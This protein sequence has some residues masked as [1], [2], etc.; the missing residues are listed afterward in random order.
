M[1]APPP[2]PPPP[3]PPLP[4]PTAY[5][6]F[7]NNPAPL[8]SVAVGVFAVAC[9][10]LDHT[11]FGTTNGAFEG[12]VIAGIVAVI[13]GVAGLLMAI[14]YGIASAVFSIIG[15]GLGLVAAIVE[16]SSPP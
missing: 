14:R 12:A 1:S 10:A 9:L 15:I 13:A 8:G 7:K 11:G 6:R 16:L 5:A 4:P 2:P 3:P